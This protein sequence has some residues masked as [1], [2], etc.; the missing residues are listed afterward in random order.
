MKI[1]HSGDL[2]LVRRQRWRV[3][4]VTR[5]LQCQLVT[6]LGIGAANSGIERRFLMPF[7][8]VDRLPWPHGC[9][10]VGSRRWRGACRSLLAETAPPGA[11]RT[12]A[13][14]RLDLWPHQ[15]EP[16]MAMVAGRGCRVLLADDVGLG[17]TIQAGLILTELIDRGLADRVLVLVPAGLREQW[18]DELSQRF[19]I[20][21]RVVDVSDIRRRTASLPVGLNPWSTIP[22]AVASID[23]VKRPEVLAAVNA[24]G[25]DVVVVDE[26]HGAASDS[27]RHAAVSTVCRRA[28]YVV[29]LTA[30]P[31]NGDSRAFA[32]L[33]DIGGHGD[34]LLVFRRTRSSV[35]LGARRRVHRLEVRMSPAEIRMHALLQRFA[36]VVESER[37]SDRVRLAL[38]VL[39][40][41]ALSSPMSLV[42]SVHRRLAALAT[43]NA[44]GPRQLGLAFDDAGGELDS[45]DD[46]PLWPEDCALEDRS[47]E[48]RLLQGLAA[49][50]ALAAERETKA[51]AVRRLIRRVKE[52]VVVF[53]EYRD[54]LLRLRDTLSMTASVLH[55]G[56]ARPARRAAVDDFGS[57]RSAI[58]LA[59]DAGGEGLNLHARCRVVINLELPWNPM[60]LEQRIGRVD[61]IGQGRTVHAF[62]LVARASGEERILRR[63][64]SRIA[65][66]R[67][68]IRAAD[69]L[70]DAAGTDVPVR[71]ASAALTVPESGSDT[72]ESN[73]ETVDLGREAAAEAARLLFTRRITRDGDSAVRHALE[74]IGTWVARARRHQ[75]RSRLGRDALAVLLVEWEDGHG[76]VRHSMVVPLAL[77]LTS[78]LAPLGS[79]WVRSTLRASDSNLHAAAL[80]VSLRSESVALAAASCMLQVRLGRERA[81]TRAVGG[82][83]DALR[84]TGLFDRRAEREFLA[85]RAAA[86]DARRES[87][88]RIRRLEQAAM[89][90]RRRPRLLL[91]LVP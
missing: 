73:R 70:A 45:S 10:F 3:V 19:A 18:S 6:A 83:A 29:L 77:H 74:S 11:L 76:Q 55:G 8:G 7:E 42:Q 40:K 80:D 34:R 49:A 37:S 28:G 4:D 78:A 35:A 46:V 16:A 26:A 53:T 68:E 5:Y 57:G 30:T 33:C 50:A 51:A 75:T 54:T 65:R 15:L 72:A 56:L 62:H 21:A 32:A 82:S 87:E 17:K 20:D 1:P 9:R 84:Q 23:Y 90:T 22:V 41:R 48:R 88:G 39:Q 25:W 52:P 81:I 14:A 66:A 67:R 69:P 47:R 36:R 89:F 12:A 31:H 58:L 86:D 61:R 13:R 44:D 85:D 64:Q 24:C 63:L 27:E 38:S 60:R 59:T 91:V 79:S 2:V 71:D 43:D